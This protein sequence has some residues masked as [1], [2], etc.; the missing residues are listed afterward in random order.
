MP[1]VIPELVI[2]LASL[3]SFSKMGMTMGF[4]TMVFAHVTFCLPFVII[5]LRSRIANFDSSIEEAAMDL[6]ANQWH[7]LKRVTIPMLTPGIIS[8]ALLSITLS[9]DDVIISYF[10]SGAGGY[11]VPYQGIR[12]GQRQDHYKCICHIN[13]MIVG[14]V[15]IYLLAGHLEGLYQSAER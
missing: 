12:N 10:V 6:G 11:H 15:V 14:I 4:A 7:T 13:F 8:G 9:I 2:G 3:A 1:I 5:T